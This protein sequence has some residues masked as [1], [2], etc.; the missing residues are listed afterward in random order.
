MMNSILKTLNNKVRAILKNKEGTTSVEFALIAP[1]LIATYFATVEV[2]MAY[3]DKEKVE[4]VAETVADLVA[5]GKTI[6]AS[7]LDDIFLLTKATL[8]QEQENQI[9]IIVTEVYTQPNNQGNPET[10]VTWSRSK[11]RENEK[12]PNSDYDELPAG[13]ATNYQSLIITELE[14]SHNSLYGQVIKGTKVYDR[15]FINKPRFSLTI[16]CDDC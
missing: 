1:I 14:F 3:L 11:T 6:T 4:N 7:E 8:S 15:R 2:S 5:R 10:T 12:L 13:M 9:N 16:P